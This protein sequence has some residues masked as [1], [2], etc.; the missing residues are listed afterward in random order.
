MD[1]CQSLITFPICLQL[2]A[3]NVVNPIHIDGEIGLAYYGAMP[4]GVAAKSV[5]SFSNYGLGQDVHEN[6]WATRHG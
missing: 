6:N 2:L 4:G 1:V 3:A 5:Y